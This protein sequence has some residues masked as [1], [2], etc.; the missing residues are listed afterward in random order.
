MFLIVLVDTFGQSKPFAKFNKKRTY[1][2]YNFEIGY[3]SHILEDLLTLSPLKNI[4]FKIVILDYLGQYIAILVHLGHL[5]AI[6]VHL[7]HLI[8]ILVYLGH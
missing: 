5:I 7:G 4:P 3:R 6:L 8:T 2:A 1:K